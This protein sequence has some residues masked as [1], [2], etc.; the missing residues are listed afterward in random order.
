LRLIDSFAIHWVSCEP[1]IL[2]AASKIKVSGGISVAD[3]WIGATAVVNDATLV[4]KDPEF[5]SF[6]QIS[7]EFLK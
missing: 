6:A 7:Q 1:A 5:E 3:S 4:R 2:D